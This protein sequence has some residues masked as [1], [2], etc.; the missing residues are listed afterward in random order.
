MA[1]SSRFCRSR[2][3]RAWAAGWDVED[4][5]GLR[6][7]GAGVKEGVVVVVEDG[8]EG[9]RRRTTRSFMCGRWFVAIA[10]RVGSSGCG[11]KWEG[12]KDTQALAWGAR[13]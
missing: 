11:R 4:E 5:G 13:F 6:E 10:I 3:A 7:V 2:A 9:K 8:E 12:E 1:A